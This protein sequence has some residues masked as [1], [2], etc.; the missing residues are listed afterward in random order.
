MEGSAKSYSMKKEKKSSN[1]FKWRWYKYLSDL[2]QA[3]SSLHD[4]FNISIIGVSW[5]LQIYNSNINNS[6]ALID[7]MPTNVIANILCAIC[8]LIPLYLSCVI[9]LSVSI[10]DEG[11]NTDDLMTQ[12]ETKNS[13]LTNITATLYKAHVYLIGPI[14]LALCF[15]GIFFE[16]IA[17]S[18]DIIH[19]RHIGWILIFP[20][21]L[22][23]ILILVHTFFVE[24]F[25]P[26]RSLLSSSTRYTSIIISATL[27]TSLILNQAE[28]HLSMKNS[29]D[30]RIIILKFTKM[31]LPLAALG[32]SK[33]IA[34]YY[35]KG[36][37]VVDSANS[38]NIL[39]NLLQIICVIVESSYARK[40]STVLLLVLPLPLVKLL[41][42]LS[43]NSRFN[44]LRNSTL[45]LK[46]I[47]LV[48]I[49]LKDARKVKFLNEEAYFKFC[50]EMTSY[51]GKETGA[52]FNKYLQDFSTSNEMSSTNLGTHFVMY[53]FEKLQEKEHRPSFITNF[54]R[55]YFLNDMSFNMYHLSLLLGRLKS[56]PLSIFEEYAFYTV[57]RSIQN[58]IELIYLHRSHHSSEED[59]F[60]SMDSA[61]LQNNQHSTAA[62]KDSRLEI[63]LC[64]RSML[65][66]QS[67]QETMDT[68]ISLVIKFFD[69]LSQTKPKINSIH[70]D[71]IRINKY[72]L[73]CDRIFSVLVTITSSRIHLSNY[74]YSYAVFIQKIFNDS[75]NAKKLVKRYGSSLNKKNSWKNGSM[76]N[77]VSKLEK[78]VIIRVDSE[79]STVGNIK[80]V[81]GQSQKML[82]V[83]N[84]IQIGQQISDMFHSSIADAHQEQVKRHLRTGSDSCLTK[85]NESR[86]IKCTNSNGQFI[87]VK[88]DGI[89]EPDL[90]QGLHYVISMR[91]ILSE[92]NYIVVSN[93]H[94]IIGMSSEI[95]NST[96]PS[97]YLNADIKKV[98]SNLSYS[99]YHHLLH[100]V[101][102]K[103]GEFDER[104]SQEIRS[105]KEMTDV[106]RDD[107][108]TPPQDGIDILILNDLLP[109]SEPSHRVSATFRTTGMKD[110]G[111][112]YIYETYILITASL[113]S[114]EN[115][116]NFNYN[117]SATQD[118]TLNVR[119]SVGGVPK[120]EPLVRTKRIKIPLDTRNENRGIDID[121]I[122]SE[123]MEQSDGR[124]KAEK[125]L[126]I[127]DNL[128]R[129][130]R[131]SL[132]K[133][134]SRT[135]TSEEK[136]ERQNSAVTNRLIN[137]ISA[138]PLRPQILYLVLIQVIFWPICLYSVITIKS[139]YQNG[140]MNLVSG[141]ESVKRVLMNDYQVRSCGIN[142]YEILLQNSNQI[143][144]NPERF[145]YIGSTKVKPSRIEFDDNIALLKSY[146][147][148]MLRYSTTLPKSVNQK[149]FQFSAQFQAK[150]GNATQAEN[151]TQQL[152]LYEVP[153]AAL[154]ILE[155]WIPQIK[156]ERYDQKLW[157]DYNN[158][159]R[160]TMEELISKTLTEILENDNLEFKDI[161]RNSSVIVFIALSIGICLALC[162]LLL[163]LIIK[164]KLER[165]YAGLGYL[166]ES[167]LMAKQQQIFHFFNLGKKRNQAHE[168]FY[169]LQINNEEKFVKTKV[170]RPF[171]EK[172]KT[173][174]ASIKVKMFKKLQKNPLDFYGLGFT[175]L[176]MFSL[177]QIISVTE[178]YV[179]GLLSE[180]GDRYL[181]NMLYL[182]SY[183]RLLYSSNLSILQ[184]LLAMT[185]KSGVK[186]NNRFTLQYFYDSITSCNKIF[187]D[188]LHE[189]EEYLAKLNTRKG[190]MLGFERLLEKPSDYL[191]Y[192][193]IGL[194]REQF[195]A[196]GGG[197]LGQNIM[198][199]HHWRLNNYQLTLDFF[200]ASDK[201]GVKNLYKGK[202][203]NDLEFLRKY[204]MREETF[205]FQDFVF[206][207]LIK[208]IESD[209]R[210]QDQVL[211]LVCIVM[212]IVS[213]TLIRMIQIVSE[214]SKISISCY[215][216]LPIESFNTNT[217]LKSHFTRL[218]KISA[219]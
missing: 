192:E 11:K 39:F 173:R 4:Y 143:V 27:S 19:I 216:I 49:Q 162:I 180:K 207:N 187:I 58:R 29:S 88:I 184:T 35:N 78:S 142:I 8:L 209:G 147:S 103:Q 141:R 75:N 63:Y 90:S 186:T 133:S 57:E 20:S 15:N 93:S 178:I 43:P 33:F 206:Q 218:H 18:K 30:S 38:L 174:Q 163:S 145:A 210:I 120:K 32:V 122:S 81:S 64:L 126:T 62:L 203:F 171:T 45:N 196:L 110:K 37:W 84:P 168:K 106:Y 157:R 125:G 54:M 199:L 82:N 182:N 201:A 83:E 198:K 48:I 135:I 79:P 36:S 175:T 176:L 118:M 61:S 91:R 97:K 205:N 25:L 24:S 149:F 117:S 68:V 190:D 9:L 183:Q 34:I 55:L 53:L 69:S 128:S 179:V 148:E 56:F 52:H 92:T 160:F 189:I 114:M 23:I 217:L 40:L 12:L 215:F 156:W 159:I 101:L 102:N 204:V 96:A 151:V 17:L 134:N 181:E 7:I 164:K 113:S 195:E 100:N 22:S 185:I 119:Q 10:K 80:W 59:R 137:L 193:S 73:K 16:K 153:R 74:S 219:F 109:R 87:E 127:I 99:Y 67:L 94:S 77:S 191:N 3:S 177:M 116:H 44:L 47:L 130:K 166:S 50:G 105:F 150:P 85:N 139:N 155:D 98:C 104:L 41:R 13:T 51:I 42:N 111:G 129:R 165:F 26:T 31:V 208:N 197:S 131:R 121:I 140:L 46:Q 66:Y 200:I 28:I 107:W 5:W 154:Q 169:N 158:L 1:R 76:L 138:S 170:R 136:S 6:Y 123:E 132:N 86:F 115:S 65:M 188:S 144:D 70:S 72:K 124:W 108:D 71:M 112:K 202:E 172:S 167:E 211:I 214:L 212:I 14:C 95:L 2:Q 89:L 161:K 194:N 152:N 21:F 60:Y 146:Y 213:T